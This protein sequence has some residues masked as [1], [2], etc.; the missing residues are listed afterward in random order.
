MKRKM[1]LAAIAFLT[2]SFASA[3]Q[4]QTV[5]GDMWTQQAE[6]SGLFSPHP[7]FCSSTEVF[8]T[9]DGGMLGYC[10]E[11]NERSAAVWVTAKNTCM[12]VGKR[13]PEPAEFQYACK[14]PPSGLV[15]MTGNGE[16]V[17]NSAI[18][19]SYAAGG[20]DTVAVP[21]MGYNSCY[22]GG[23]GIIASNYSTSGSEDSL[24]YRC[25]R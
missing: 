4:A 21:H 5:H 11:K 22:R 16:W 12:G 15:D 13:L 8:V 14:N 9:V 1:I 3:V 2:F 24:A 19:L 20:L 6:K 25:V 7:N 18:P 23:F 17:S 10:I